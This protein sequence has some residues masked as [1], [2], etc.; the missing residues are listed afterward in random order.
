MEY[1]LQ[2]DGSIDWWAYGIDEWVKYLDLEEGI[3]VYP[4]PLVVGDPDDAAD[5]AE[6]L[7]SKII[8]RE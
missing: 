7:V 8:E 6:M 4:I 1:N 2:E 3:Q 5:A